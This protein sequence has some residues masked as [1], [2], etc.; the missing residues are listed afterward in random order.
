MLS[1]K[2]KFLNPSASLPRE[3]SK[4]LDSLQFE[5][6]CQALSLLHWSLENNMEPNQLLVTLG[7]CSSLFSIIWRICEPLVTQDQKALYSQHTGARKSIFRN[8]S[9]FCKIQ[10]LTHFWQKSSRIK[11]FEESKFPEKLIFCPNVR[12]ISGSLGGT[13]LELEHT[14]STL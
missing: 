4:K 14:C 5:Y 1:I 8:F 10:I 2:L 11:I 3:N 6:F 7:L 12:W 9:F 13:A